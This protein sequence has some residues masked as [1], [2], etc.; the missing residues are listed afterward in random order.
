MFRQPQRQK[1][2]FQTDAIRPTALPSASLTSAHALDE[3]PADQTSD[4]YLN[5]VYED[6]NKKVDAEIETL[7]DGMT[8]LVQIASVS[9]CK[10]N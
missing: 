1:E 2:D 6:W 7:V 5:G 8:D 4:E 9:L 3:S 10:D